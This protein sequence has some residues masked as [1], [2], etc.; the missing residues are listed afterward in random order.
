MRSKSVAAEVSLT[1]VS[2]VSGDWAQNC[3]VG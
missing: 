1:A 3:S 2:G